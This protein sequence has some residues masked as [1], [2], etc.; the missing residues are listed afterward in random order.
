VF[1]FWCLVFGF[2]FGFWFWFWLLISTFA[3]RRV[4]GWRAILMDDVYVLQE[5]INTPSQTV[6]KCSFRK[7]CNLFFLF[8][9]FFF[10]FRWERARNLKVKINLYTTNLTTIEKKHF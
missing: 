4:R 8:S 3:G 10:L 1:W 6:F 7:N 9:Q 2:G 5:I